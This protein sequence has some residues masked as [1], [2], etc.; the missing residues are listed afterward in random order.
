M[1]RSVCSAARAQHVVCRVID[2]EMKKWCLFCYVLLWVAILP[3][4]KTYLLPRL[5]KVKTI[6][7]ETAQ[8]NGFAKFPELPPWLVENC[9]RLGFIEPTPV[10]EK[11]LPV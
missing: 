7:R 11:A 3:S 10:Q 5:R 2:R 6:S 9:N 8:T 4:S 1:N